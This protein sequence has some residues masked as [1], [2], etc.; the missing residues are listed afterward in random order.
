MTAVASNVHINAAVKFQ[1]FL[2]FDGPPEIIDESMPVSHSKHQFHISADFY[3]MQFSTNAFFTA[4]CSDI[5]LFQCHIH[6][7]IEHIFQLTFYAFSEMTII[8]VHIF[9]IGDRKSH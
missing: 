8:S 4:I 7:S 3:C 9:E 2:V 5:D 6:F 1:Q